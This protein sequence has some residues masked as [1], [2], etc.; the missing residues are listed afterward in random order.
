MIITEHSKQ[1]QQN[2]QRSQVLMKYSPGQITF[3]ATSQASV[4]LRK[5]KSY[6]AFFSD[7]NTMRLE[8]NHEKN[9]NKKPPE[10]HQKHV[11]VKQYATKQPKD[12]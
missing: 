4:N 10:K 3:W 1:K 9:S 12:N 8:I 11:E 2:I 7:H 6:Q 5:L